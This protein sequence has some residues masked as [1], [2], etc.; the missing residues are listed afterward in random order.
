[1][2]PLL[3]ISQEAGECCGWENGDSGVRMLSFIPSLQTLGRLWAFLGLTSLICKN[4]KDNAVDLIWLFYNFPLGISNIRKIWVCDGMHGNIIYGLISTEHHRWLCIFIAFL[5]HDWS[6]RDGQTCSGS[7]FKLF[8]A[9]ANS[10][11]TTWRWEDWG[12]A[13]QVL[14]KYHLLATSQCSFE[15]F[16]H[17]TWYRAFQGLRCFN[18]FP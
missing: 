4:E 16:T 12:I 7:V 8:V 5:M 2:V 11:H 1:M 13:P 17:S 18:G 10:H 15:I 6:G 14:C 3:E 9:R